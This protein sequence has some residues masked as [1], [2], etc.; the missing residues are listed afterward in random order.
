MWRCCA[1]WQRTL[2][3]KWNGREFAA[4]HGCPVPELYWQGGLFSRPPLE[5]LPDNFVVRPVWGA[6]QRG[7]LLISD[8]VELL[9]QES[10]TLPE[11]RRTLSL[12]RRLSH[13]TRILIEELVTS[14]DRRFPLECK[15]HCFGDAVA[16]VQV[17]ERVGFRKATHRF[18]TPEW[19]PFPDRMNVFLD[20]AEIRDPPGCL[21]S[22]LGHAARVG[23]ALGT[24]MRIDFFVADRG[25]VFSELSSVPLA[26][27]DFTP[28][29]DEL[30]GAL[31]AEKV[32]AA[33]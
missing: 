7:V 20:E 28:Y 8:G 26:G 31:W 33:T 12:P 22:I 30:F 25:C 4:K 1:L 32:P 5:S 14:S 24:Y 21:E 15:C 17:I 2:L 18:Y 29:C 3:N 27:R 13:P 23:A 16:A 11:L 10:A 19:E 9:R 6:F